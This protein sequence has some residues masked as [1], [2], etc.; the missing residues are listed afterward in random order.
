M[1]RDETMNAAHVD[2]NVTTHVR[3]S[4][5]T[6]APYTLSRAERFHL[7]HNFGRDIVPR[8]GG[9]MTGRGVEEHSSHNFLPLSSFL[10]YNITK[11][12]A[13]EAERRT[14]PFQFTVRIT[15]QPNNNYYRASLL[16]LL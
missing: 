2:A 11:N 16:L 9:S 7:G 4:R 5:L 3:R 1:N 14:S 10:E 13:L 6:P 12:L 8:T 15:F